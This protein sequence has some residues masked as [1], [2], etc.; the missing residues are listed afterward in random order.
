MLPHEI[1]AK[2]RM[3][4]IEYNKTYIELMANGQQEEAYEVMIEQFPSYF[5]AANRT[6]K[7]AKS[8][9]QNERSHSEH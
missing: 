4:N 7:W 3:L 1:A 8:Q 9:S 6:Q 2:V 5:P